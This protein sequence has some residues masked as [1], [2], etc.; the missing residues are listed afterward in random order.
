MRSLTT[1]DF[2]AAN[3]EF[4]EFWVLN[5]FMNNDNPGDLYINLGNV[6]EDILRDSRKF[7]E[8][9]I[10]VNP[11]SAQLDALDR[12]AWGRIPR[13]PDIARAFDNT[14]R[15]QQDVGYDGVDSRSSTDELEQFQDVM[16]IYRQ[17][18]FP[19]YTMKLQGIRQMMISGVLTIPFMRRIMPEQSSV[20]V[21]LTTRRVTHRMPNKVAGSVLPKLPLPNNE[22]ID[23][24]NTLNES[25][26]YYQ[27]KIPLRTVPSNLGGAAY[28]LDTENTPFVTD[29]VTDPASDRTWY[30][31]KVPVD[32]FDTRVGVIEDFRTIRFIRMYL[33]GFQQEVTL[34]FAR[35]ELARN[36]WRRYPTSFI[37]ISGA[38]HFTCT[39]PD[40]F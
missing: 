4:L 2:Q 19:M 20:T 11:D 1:T 16:D 7:F 39:K 27:Y 33:H 23:A 6:S 24:D 5:P 26:A 29:M 8:N 28:E 21:N 34:R 15:N 10:P 30:R 36:Q 32:E 12:T 37:S 31:F 17:N 40:C 18:Y 13:I 22:D 3:I 38:D 9:G 35:F 25:E 14:G